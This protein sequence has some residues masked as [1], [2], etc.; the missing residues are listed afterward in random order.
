MVEEIG[1]GGFIPPVDEQIAWNSLFTMEELWSEYLDKVI[2][3]GA[4]NCLVIADI[5]DYGRTLH[6]CRNLEGFERSAAKYLS[7]HQMK[8]AIPTA[9]SGAHQQCVVTPFL[10]ERKS[11][12]ISI[13]IDPKI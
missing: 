3:D 6:A 12:S 8:L 5:I 7:R 4:R 11:L 2:A 9:A 1:G 10:D 13:S